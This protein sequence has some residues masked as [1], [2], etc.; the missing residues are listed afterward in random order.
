MQLLQLATLCDIVLLNKN[1]VI[2]IRPRRF[3]AAATQALRMC[4][5]FLFCRSHPSLLTIQV[6][7]DTSHLVCL[8][9]WLDSNIIVSEIS[10][11]KLQ[12]RTY[13]VCALRFCAHMICC[14][15]H[16]PRFPHSHNFTFTHS[17][18]PLFEP[19]ACH[20]CLK[21]VLL[22][23]LLQPSTRKRRRKHGFLQRLREAPHVI[24]NRLRKVLF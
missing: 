14:F 10:E 9:L 16:R 12:K 21:Q 20:H 8:Y 5:Q 22:T 13:Q 23:Y 7:G 4:T 2:H 19:Y 3:S 11:L 17:R 24:V 18:S 6:N 1:S 15:F